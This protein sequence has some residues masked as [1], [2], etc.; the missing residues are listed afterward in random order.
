[1]ILELDCGN[2][3]IKWRILAPHNIQIIVASGTAKDTEP[4]FDELRKRQEKITFCRVVS[5][6]SEAD[7]QK[8]IAALT[9]YYRIPIQQ[10]ATKAEFQGVRNGYTDPQRL[11]TDRWL[12]LLAAHHKHK[13]NTLILSFGTAVTS[14][15]IDNQ[16]QHLGGFIAPSLLLMHQQLLNNTKRIHYHSDLMASLLKPIERPADT[17]EKAVDGGCQL[18][19]QGFVD[20]QLQLAQ[21]YFNNHF[22]VYTTGG[23][24]IHFNIPHAHYTPD[25]VFIGL[26]LA[27]PY[28]EN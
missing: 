23:D 7:T 26:A 12:A 9:Q 24:A 25:L 22:N 20:I 4:L 14:D 6:R 1:M 3:L 27:C 10:A 17:T 13:K 5:V 15:F 28:M 21:R 2:T 19:L 18:M 8:L 11:G 16:G